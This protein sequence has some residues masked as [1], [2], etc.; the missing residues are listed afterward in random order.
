MALPDAHS[1]YVPRNPAL[2]RASLFFYPP[3]AD[4]GPAPASG[5]FFG[6]D[7]GFWSAVRNAV[8]RVDEE[9]PR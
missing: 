7:V 6:D 8:D 3:H 4:S 5:F 9:Q 2:R 1:D